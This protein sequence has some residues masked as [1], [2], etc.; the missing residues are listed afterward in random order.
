MHIKNEGGGILTWTISTDP[1]MNWLQINPT[2]GVNNAIISLTV[3]KLITDASLSLLLGNYE[4][5]IT[6][7]GQADTRRSPVTIPINLNIV[8][9]LG[10]SYL[11]LIKK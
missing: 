6:V 8:T 1:T 7:T 3:T 11:P 2:M 9:Y 4:T 10:N 5:V